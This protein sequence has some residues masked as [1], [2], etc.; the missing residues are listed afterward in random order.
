MDTVPDLAQAA[1]GMRMELGLSALPVKR[2]A[3]MVGKGVDSLVHRTLTNDLEGH[4]DAPQFAQGRAAFFRHYHQVNGLHATVFDGV[5]AALAQLRARGLRLA[6]VTN[7]PREF[8]VPLLT[9]VGLAAAFEVVV[10]GDDVPEKKPHPAQLLE[11]CRLLDVTPT[12]CVMLGDS[13][14]DALAAQRAGCPC[15]LVET[16]YNEGQSVDALRD[17][18]GV[19]GVYPNLPL[20]VKALLQGFP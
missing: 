19:W 11:A 20:A 1:N 7:K 16:G 8:T 17:H 4:A 9:R 15:A 2:I 10:A 13:V 14:N 3:A 12:Q 18:P 5:P 6:C